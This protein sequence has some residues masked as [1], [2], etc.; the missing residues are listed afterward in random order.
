MTYTEVIGKHNRCNVYTT[1]VDDTT[2][3]QL[4]DLLDQSFIEGEQIAIMPD[5]HAGKG[6]VETGIVE[7]AYIPVPAF[8]V[9]L[10]HL[11][12]LAYV[13]VRAYDY[14]LEV[15]HLLGVH[16]FQELLVD[17]GDAVR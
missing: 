11:V 7:I 5:C 2:L 16:A 4:K 8:P 17:G 10:P 12:Q 6:C 13:F 15:G 9:D 1:N 3:L 14:L